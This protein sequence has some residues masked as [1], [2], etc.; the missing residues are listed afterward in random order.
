MPQKVTGRTKNGLAIASLNAITNKTENEPLTNYNITI[1]DQTFGNK[2]F[3]KYNE[4]SW[5]NKENLKDA[6]VTGLF[7]RVNM[8]VTQEHIMEN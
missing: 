5:F 7:A 6:N 2:L 3:F 1:V 8:K 4:Y